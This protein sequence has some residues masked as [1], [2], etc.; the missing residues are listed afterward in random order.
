MFYEQ[1]LKWFIW[2]HYSVILD[3][4]NICGRWLYCMAVA[5]KSVVNSSIEQNLVAFLLTDIYTVRYNYI[6]RLSF[7]FLY[8]ISSGEKKYATTTLARP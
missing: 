5:R 6:L 8:N 4:V 2:C 3:R 7:D 1:F